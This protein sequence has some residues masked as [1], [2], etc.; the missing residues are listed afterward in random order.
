MN[1][2]LLMPCTAS[3]R[4]TNEKSSPCFSSL[5]SLPFCESASRMDV[6]VFTE[7]RRSPLRLAAN[8]RVLM[9][10]LNC[11]RKFKPITT[12]RQYHNPLHGEGAGIVARLV[13]CKVSSAVWEVSFHYPGQRRG[14]YARLYFGSSTQSFQ[15]C[16]KGF[17]IK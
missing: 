12:K 14:K 4:C 9:K 2:S 6:L 10:A 5:S 17:T 7:P 3:R 1:F 8:T 16:Q 11:R 13:D 15:P